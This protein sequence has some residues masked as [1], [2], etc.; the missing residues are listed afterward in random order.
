MTLDLKNQSNK[1]ADFD[2]VVK[3]VI[4][5]RSNEDFLKMLKCY[6]HNLKLDNALFLC[7]IFLLIL[8]CNL[9]NIKGAILNEEFK[10]IS[11]RIV[12]SLEGNW[13]TILALI[14]CQ[15]CLCKNMKVSVMLKFSNNFIVLSI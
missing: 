3:M 9:S 8:N 11:S 4:N 14:E 6:E 15:T 7:Q 5:N 13:D 2:K 10:Q 12:F 1:T